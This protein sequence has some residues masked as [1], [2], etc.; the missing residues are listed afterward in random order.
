M[1][2]KGYT[3]NFQPL[4]ILT[5]EQA[6]AVHRSSLDVLEQ[7]GIRFESERALKM[8][9]ENG[10]HVDYSNNR[11]RIPASLVE[12]SL[13]QCPS[14]FRM[15]SR[16]P[17]NDVMLGGSTTYFCPSPGMRIIDL[18]TWE[19][20]AAT[21]KENIDATLVIDHLDTVGLA[22]SYTPYAELEGVPG[23]LL[24][25]VSCY[26]RMKY[27]TKPNRIG[28]SMESHIW[29]LQMAQAL[30]VDVFAAMEAAPPL[31]WYGDAID[32]AWA[33]AEAGLPVEVGCGAVMG[34]TG[35]ATIAG[36]LVTANAEIISGIVMCQLV[37]PNTPI[38]ANSFVFAQNMR[39]GSPVA[40][41]I[42]VSLFQVAFNQMWRGK[43]N[44]PTMLGACGPSSAEVIGFQMGYEKGISSTLA[45]VSGASVVNVH[46]GMHVEL[47]YHPVQSILD[48][49]IAG[50]IGRYLEGIKITDETLA[51]DVINEVGPIPGSFLIHKHTRDWWQE[52]HFLPEVADRKSYPE[53]IK[54]GKKNDVENAIDKMEKILATH[55]SD[56]ALTATQE[57]DLDRI[58]RDAAKYYVSK[59]IITNEEQSVFMQALEE[60]E[61]YQ[62]NRLK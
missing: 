51:T 8:F 3:R 13:R 37:Q 50:M 23:A 4:S 10:C 11:V 19:Q 21:L 15:K 22:A 9:E 42:E 43:Y 16:N 54:G 32:C 6:E 61:T 28:S 57:E 33:C 59:S 56:P 58:I 49:D 26:H 17:K 52:E 20:R 12:E 45:A 62:A 29:E 5:D 30:G 31:T 24:L 36:T 39:T 48:H 18:D 34:G 41:G 47:T 7:T 44:I 35:P 53:W 60:A 1:T 55:E 27:F 25:P 46:G 38:L 2:R 14:N 40:G